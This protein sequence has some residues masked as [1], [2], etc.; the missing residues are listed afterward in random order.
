M[1]AR[2]P[3]TLGLTVCCLLAAQGPPRAEEALG[4]QA[5]HQIEVIDESQFR[6]E[7]EKTEFQFHPRPSDLDDGGT[8]VEE[9]LFRYTPLASFNP[10]LFDTEKVECPLVP[11]F[12]SRPISKSPVATFRT[13]FSEGA[14]IEEWAL[15]ITDYRGEIF[16]TLA[17]SG[18]PPAELPWDGR[19]AHSE[20][21]KPGFPYSFLFIIEDSGTNRYQYA[22]STFSLPSIAYQDGRNLR[23]EA[24]GHS[25]F[26]KQSA[27]PSPD[28]DRQVDRILRE[29][30]DSPSRALRV[31]AWAEQQQVADARAAWLAATL[32]KRLLLSEGQVAWE[33]KDFRGDPPGRDGLLRVTLLKGKERPDARRG[34]G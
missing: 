28:A 9:L 1:R 31:E 33:G 18:R 26:E 10:Y 11:D 34:R 15:D 14:D 6:L 23:V 16:R 20:V 32:E 22:G 2:T 8:E 25:L 3:W 24:A 7:V 5:A 17:G 30:L 29:I 19:G 13:G 4:G 12:A 27:E 21:L